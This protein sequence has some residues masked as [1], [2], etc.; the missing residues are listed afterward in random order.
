MKD[1]LKYYIF[2][3]L[4]F[5]SQLIFIHHLTLHFE[6]INLFIPIINLSELINNL[7]FN[8]FHFHFIIA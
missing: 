8:Y 3:E 5:L 7:K 1:P 4:F 2:I 6:F